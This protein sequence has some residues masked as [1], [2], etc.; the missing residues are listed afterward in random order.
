MAGKYRAYAEYKSATSKWI[1]ILPVGWGRTP[2]KGIVEIRIT[3][4][5]HETP[6]FVDDGVPFLSA[7]S[8]KNNRLDFAK[9]RGYISRAAFPIQQ[10]MFAKIW[11]YIHG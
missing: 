4:G 7:E 5:P 1:D 3:D 11:R 2:L 9:K 10:E 8:I 6:N